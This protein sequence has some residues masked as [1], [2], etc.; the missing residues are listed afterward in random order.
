MKDAE[1]ELCSLVCNFPETMASVEVVGRWQLRYEATH[2]L[3]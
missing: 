3:N 2:R 1:A